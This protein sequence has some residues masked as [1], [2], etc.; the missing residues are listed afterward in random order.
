MINL[1]R[2]LASVAGVVF[3]AATI[4]PAP[5]TIAQDQ[6][7]A[8]LPPPA[9]QPDPLSIASNQDTP[10]AQ[11]PATPATQPEAKPAEPQPFDLW[12]SKRATGDWGGVRTWMDNTGI[13]FSMVYTP[14]FQNNFY[15]GNETHNAQEFT[16][17]LRINLNLDFEKM[18]LIPGGFFFIRGKSSYN[19]GL[20]RDVGSISATSWGITAGDDEFFL[21]KWWYGQRF[22][23]K[24][25]ELRF[26]KLLSPV[27]LI[28]TNA[29][30]GNPWDQFMNS[31]LNQNPTVP[32]RKSLGAYLK[33]KPTDWFY[34]STAAIDAD[35]PN[36]NRCWATDVGLHGGA[37]YVGYWEFGLTPTFQSAKGPMPGNYRF[38]FHC[39]PR[40]LPVYMPAT[41]P[42]IYRRSHADDMGMYL[43]FDQLMWK[44]NSDPKDKQG[45]GAFFRYGMAH[46][47]INRIAQFWSV[48]A[49]YQG[50]IPTRDK[51]VLAFGVG[52]SLLSHTLRHKVNPLADRE[53]V[54]ELYY[55]IQITP[56]LIVYPDLQ[57]IVNPGGNQ[58]AHD[59]L[60]GGVKVKLT[61]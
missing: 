1:A 46:Q 7:T 47:D 3:A 45:F 60:V 50:L 10:P 4:I 44:E 16:G 17:D 31:V 38:G 54:Y 29:Y 27:D 13:D 5:A 23:D 52:D 37:H 41:V 2:R 53:T 59:A 48:G 61:L 6:P 36:P 32:H 12:T 55:A 24:K 25:I 35:E 56:W 30:A 33:I 51:D 57:L 8:K 43:S 22:L 19:T 42:A 11:P 21:D 39:D 26:G 40:P 18:K 28:D 34:F 49:Q 20:G 15:G 58:D 9:G 14:V